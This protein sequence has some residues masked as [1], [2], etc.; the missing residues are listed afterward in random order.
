MRARRHML[1]EDGSAQNRIG[2]RESTGARFKQLMEGKNK[3]NPD[4]LRKGFPQSIKRAFMIMFLMD[5]SQD[6]REIAI[7]ASCW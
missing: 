5:R 4:R 6:R 7:L 2:R 3:D 1:V